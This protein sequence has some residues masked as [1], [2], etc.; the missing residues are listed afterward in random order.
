MRIKG[1][2]ILILLSIVLSA[3]FDE[4]NNKKP[5]IAKMD[6]SDARML[7]M[8]SSSLQSSPSA[9]LGEKAASKRDVV[10]YK[11][12]ED[13]LFI[14]VKSYDKDGNAVNSNLYRPQIVHEVSDDYVYVIFNW[15]QPLP[16]HIYLVRKSDGAVFRGPKD[17]WPIKDCDG[18]EKFVYAQKS[19]MTVADGSIYYSLSPE[20]ALNKIDTAD[21]DHLTDT[22]V[23][24]QSDRV[25][26]AWV[27]KNGNILYFGR[28]AD[29][30][31]RL[32]RPTGAVDDVSYL[33][34]KVNTW[35]CQIFVGGDGNIYF[36]QYQSNTGNASQAV[37]YSIEIHGLDVEEGG[38]INT[39]L[40]GSMQSTDIVEQKPFNLGRKIRFLNARGKVIAV[41]ENGAVAEIYNSTGNLF[42]AENASLLVDSVYDA[43]IGDSY[44]FIFGA[45]ADDGNPAIYRIDIDSH[46]GTKLPIPEDY[47]LYKFEATSN[48][49]V[50]FHALR[51]ADGADVIGKIGTDNEI[52]IISEIVGH[53]TVELIRVN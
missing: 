8:M 22:Q 18:K 45:S 38:T 19:T 31:T 3:C 49:E 12:T 41:R 37:N 17:S 48:D 13:G 5:S 1:G 25:Y 53:P 2:L 47:E 6:I 4:D 32:I 10:L 42:Q 20:F 52:V 27:D 51:Y 23:S 7:V 15:L 11:L 14:E 46:M 44:Y 36:P 16:W 28:A 50:V 26:H 34:D 39:H 21:P 33:F 24:P 43:Q 40:Y 9:E 30:V 29:D 35:E